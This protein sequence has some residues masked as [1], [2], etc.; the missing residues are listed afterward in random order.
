MSERHLDQLLD[1]VALSGRDDVVVGA[2]PAA[3]SST[4]RARNPPAYPQSRCASRF[5]RFSASASPSLMRAT[6][7]VTL[8]VTNSSP[9][10]GDSWL[11]RMP[12]TAIEVVALA[13]VDG[14]VVRE[15]LRDAVG[16]ARVERRQLG[17]RHLAHLAVHLAR[18]GL[19]EADRGIH[20]TNGLE[21]PRDALRV[22]LARQHRLI[23]GG[24]HERHRGEVVELV[25]PDVID[26]SNQREL[27]EQVCRVEGEAGRAGARY[28]SSWSCWRAERCRRPRS[29][30][31]GAARPDTDPSCPV[32]PLISARFAH[33]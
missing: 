33:D 10:R 17:L 19:V 3:A 28:A 30:C 24:R 1:G 6:P 31:R 13:V 25:R 23:P 12:E 11:K 27:I 18:R 4:S 22:V 5:P 15:D 32:I 8:R 14:D 20:L 9:R 2:C 16:A 26:D 7:S 29:P 21:R